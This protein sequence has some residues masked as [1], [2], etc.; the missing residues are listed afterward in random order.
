[1]KIGCSGTLPRDKFQKWKILGMFSKIVYQK[2]ITDLQDAGN[3]SKLRITLLK[4]IDK[5]VESNTDLLFNL[6]STKKFRPDEFGF[7]DIAFDD[8]SRAENEYFVKHYKELYVPVFE[9]VKN[10]N[11]NTLILFDRIEIGQ[12]LFEYAKELYQNKNVFYID[13]S[14]AVKDR[15]EI[16]ANFEKSDG[17]LLFAQTTT[18]STGI[19]IKRLSNL[20]FLTGSKS[21][22]QVLQSIGRT[23]R[24]H[25]SKTEAHLI[26]I[27]WNF[28]YS[29]RHLAE[30]LKIY[31]DAYNKKP[32]EVI[33]FEIQ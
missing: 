18:F 27:S 3:I 17:N 33:T 6:N 4:I 12:N 5:Y 14:I 15:E 10:L 28:K 19:S 26:D 11:S 23:L 30:R 7:S 29:H 31:K 24:L 16:R 9:Y 20:I 21:F 22:S 1:M 13:G 25:E 32:D 8:A 2:K